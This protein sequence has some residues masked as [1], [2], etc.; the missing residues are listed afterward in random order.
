MPILKNVILFHFQNGVFSAGYVAG[1]ALG[2]KIYKS[3]EN[4]YVNFG[5]SI[6][7]GLAG[8]IA[9]LLIKE[10][11]RPNPLVVADT[12]ARGF[13]NLDNLKQSL[14]TSFRSRPRSGRIHVILLVVNFAIFMFCLNT[15]HFDYLLVI[16]K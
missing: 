9:G 1:T 3:Y 12:G 13:F 15:N 10:S 11:V 14:M 5:I 16:N 7:L 8:I 2:G 4:Y 6:G